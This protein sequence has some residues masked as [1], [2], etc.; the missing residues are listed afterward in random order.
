MQDADRDARVDGVVVEALSSMDQIDEVLAI[1]HESFTQPWTRAMYLADLS[2]P[3]VSHVFI[4]RDPERRA[5]G[6]CSFWIVVDELHLNNLAVLPLNRRSGVASRLLQAV[7]EEG[8]RRGVARVMLEVRRSNEAAKGLYFRW[9]F[10]VS[11][12]RR[13]YYTTP[14]EDALV[15]WRQEPPDKRSD[16]RPKG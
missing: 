13:G 10:S 16:T 8:H 1:E 4:A 5:I 2:N 9:G 6:F 15:L 11:A 14:V 7:L 3:G 12:V